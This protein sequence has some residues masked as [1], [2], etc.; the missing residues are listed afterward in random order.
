MTLR[1]TA[2]LWLTVSCALAQDS[3]GLYA[4]I[5]TTAGTITAQLFEDQTPNTVRN[6]VALAE[7][8]KATKIQGM[9]VKRR[10]YDT[11]TFHRTIKGFMIQT[12][13]V[14]GTGRSDCGIPF[15]KDEIVDSLK[16]DQAGRLAVANQGRPNS[17]ACQFFITVGRPSGIDGQYTIFG[18]V[19]SG[20]DVAKKINEAPA[21]GDRPVKPVKINSVTIK[22]QK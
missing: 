20:L 19:V 12:G 3:P 9:M 11:L 6:F 22:R 7:G 8:T 4:T 16:F 15:L 17:G 18:Q 1:L 10:Y 21:T 2:L 14:E 13:D 5:D